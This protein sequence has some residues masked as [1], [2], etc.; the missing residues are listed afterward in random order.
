VDFSRGWLN[1]AIA[2]SRNAGAVSSVTPNGQRSG[3][4]IS[5]RHSAFTK[6]N[7]AQLKRLLQF[8]ESM[9]FKTIPLAFRYRMIHQ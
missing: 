1:A 3:A 7:A 4:L 2:F 6:Q 8:V 9:K 5:L